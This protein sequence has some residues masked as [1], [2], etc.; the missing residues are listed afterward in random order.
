MA[1]YIYG[2]VCPMSGAIRYIGKAQ[3]PKKRLSAHISGALTFAYSHHTARWIRKLAEDGLKPGLKILEQVAQDADWREVERRWIRKALD[4]GWP[5]T[6]STQGGE[7]LCYIDPED[8]ARW[9]ANLER[10]MAAYRA[11]DEY[12]EAFAVFQNAS[13]SPEANARRIDG[14]VD[15]W[16]DP[17]KRQRMMGALERT[18]MSP[19]AE[20]NRIDGLKKNWAENREAMI[21]KIWTDE[22]RTKHRAAR[23]ASWQ[24][25]DKRA[26]Q[27]KRWSDPEARAKQAAELATRQARIQAARTPEVR[28]KQAASLKAN[29]A[30][31]K[32]MKNAS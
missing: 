11:S 1:I 15:A 29:W 17:E 13:R 32:A 25:P 2:L 22:T 14:L 4:Q 18:R 6:N 9:R 16:R 23:V 7:G 30:K 10:S 28:A 27:M 24:D 19:E 26:A 3:K 5:L 12:K 8:E 31:R 20:A 21:E